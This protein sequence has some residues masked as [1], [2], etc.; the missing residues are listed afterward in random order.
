MIRVFSLLAFAAAAV[1]AAAQAPEQERFVVLRGVDKIVGRARTIEVSTKEPA[2]FGLLTITAQT[3]EKA[4]PTERPEVSAFLQIRERTGE[5]GDTQVFSG[6]MFASSPS[7]NALEHPVYDLW[8]T[9]CKTTSG[10]TLGES[11]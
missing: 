8:V 9:D 10:D 6:W 2:R 11:R 4:P 1:T 3:C 5:P 7:L